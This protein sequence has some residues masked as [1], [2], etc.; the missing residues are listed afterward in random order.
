MTLIICAETSPPKRRSPSFPTTRHGRSNIR[1][2]NISMPSVISWNAASQSSSSSGASQRASKRPPEITGPSSLSLPSSYGCDKCPQ[3]LRGPTLPG[4]GTNLQGTNY[5]RAGPGKARPLAS[6]QIVGI[7][8][9]VSAQRPASRLFPS[10]VRPLK[11]RSAGNEENTSRRIDVFPGF[12][13]RSAPLTPLGR[14]LPTLGMC[15]ARCYLSDRA[16][17]F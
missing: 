1:S 13:R 5:A 9:S 6:F 2:I 16:G 7:A 17:G 14:R 4:L 11:S 10:K 12:R 3:D 8:V 15:H